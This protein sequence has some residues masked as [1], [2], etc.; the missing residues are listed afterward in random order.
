MTQETH[1][2]PPASVRQLAVIAQP[3]G[4]LF[5]ETDRGKADPNELLFKAPID[6]PFEF[7]RFVSESGLADQ[8]HMRVNLSEHSDRFMVMPAGLGRPEQ[9]QDLFNAAFSE[10]K[11]GEL[12]QFPLSDSKQVFVCALQKDRLDTYSKIFRNLHIY[13]PT[14]LLTE[15]TL[16]QAKANNESVLTAYC[17]GKNLH[18]AAAKPG[19]LLFVNAFTTKNTKEA[20]YYF[21]RVV[22]QLQ[23]DQQHLHAFVCTLN[24]KA[25]PLKEALT[26]YLSRLDH[27]VFTGFP[28]APVSSFQ[29]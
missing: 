16:Q 9:V 29:P 20:T 13:N 5:I 21:L 4:F 22:E 27:L 6:F 24:N 7:E 3:E 26:P 17:F 25:H 14:H 12:Y 1:L 8:P 2:Y 23:L 18:I 11:R 28:E 10:D 15:W 19:T